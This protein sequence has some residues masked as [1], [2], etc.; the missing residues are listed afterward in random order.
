MDMRTR[1]EVLPLTLKHLQAT[2]AD[3][4][5]LKHLQLLCDS[6]RSAQARVFAAADPD[7]LP[8]VHPRIARSEG[9]VILSEG[10]CLAMHAMCRDCIYAT[11]ADTLFGLGRHFLNEQSPHRK[12]G[13]M[14]PPEWSGGVR[15]PE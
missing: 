5:E 2:H 13:M 1:N 4:R 14:Y 9:S 12:R 10:H 6:Y 7:D 3:L 8:P 11:L 15:V